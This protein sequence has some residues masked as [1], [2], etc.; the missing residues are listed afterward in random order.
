[1]K[2]GFQKPFDRRPGSIQK[3]P[4]GVLVCKREVPSRKRSWKGK[5]DQS[6]TCTQRTLTCTTT[7]TL[8]NRKRTLL[9]GAPASYDPSNPIARIRSSNR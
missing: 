3:V 1:V 9:R 5:A 4:G 7:A 2:S 6:A 8:S